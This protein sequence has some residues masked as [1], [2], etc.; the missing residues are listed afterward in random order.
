M[1]G[2]TDYEILLLAVLFI[3]KYMHSLSGQVLL[4]NNTC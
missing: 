2:L 3:L 4:G 1:P